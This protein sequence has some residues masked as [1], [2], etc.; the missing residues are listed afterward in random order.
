[1]NSILIE[2][3]SENN[4]NIPPT[5]KSDSILLDGV[6]HSQFQPVFTQFLKGTE[7]IGRVSET[8]M[9][10][11]GDTYVDPGL[12]K[13]SDKSAIYQSQEKFGLKN[14]IKSDRQVK[15][16]RGN[17]N[18]VEEKSTPEKS[19]TRSKQTFQNDRAAFSKFNSKSVCPNKLN[20]VD[21]KS[22]FDDVSNRTL[23]DSV[24]H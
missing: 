18:P 12:N 23:F 6:S 4:K 20:Q 1:M 8:L 22:P 9:K 13:S 16:E 7:L 19:I 5:K 11:F 21:D 2:N 14:Q 15:S 10:K 24:H 3:P 17:P